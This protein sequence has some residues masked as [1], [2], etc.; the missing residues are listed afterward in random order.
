[1]KK[2]IQMLP[3]LVIASFPLS[4]NA[5]AV[6]GGGDNAQLIDAANSVLWT[7]LALVGFIFAATGAT[8]Y[9]FWRK[10][11]RSKPSL[12]TIPNLTPADAAD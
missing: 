5:C 11:K 9:F 7:L 12:S 2:A 4:A 8:I 6:C 3:C 1:M 10:S